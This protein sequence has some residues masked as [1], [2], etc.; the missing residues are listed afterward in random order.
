M[1]LIKSKKYQNVYSY[2]AKKGTLYTVRF[3]YYGFTR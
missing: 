1:K 3:V 2:K